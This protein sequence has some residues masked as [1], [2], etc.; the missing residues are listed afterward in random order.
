MK[1]SVALLSG[2]L[3]STV[4]L[5]LAVREGEI[6]EALT[7]DYGQR[8]C[9]REKEAAGALCRK[10]SI[11]HTVIELPW[12]AKATS[13][14]LVNRSAPIPRT[15]AD[16]LSE[17][18]ESR[19]SAVWVPNRNGAFVSIAASI[20]ESAGAGCVIA[21]FNAEEAASFPDNSAGFVEATNRALSYSTMNSVA[22]ESPTLLMKKED[23]AREALRLEIE[24]GSFWFCYDG[25]ES[26]CGECESC[27]RTIR[28]FERIG[29][30]K[31]LER[32]F[33]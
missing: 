19:T 9:A 3:D 29:A 17:E 24:P 11:H 6:A 25:G 16:D 4:A 8:A 7:F 5:M 20:A 22:V 31:M 23:I 1:R 26:P 12:L 18:S 33:Q 2:G 30:G 28:A 27:A 21:G 14:A 15:G 10:L 13:T 32:I